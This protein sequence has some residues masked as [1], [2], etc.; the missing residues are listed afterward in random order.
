MGGELTIGLS[1]LYPEALRHLDVIASEGVEI[2]EEDVRRILW[3]RLLSG[4][5]I[6][7]REGAGTLWAGWHV[8]VIPEGFKIWNDVPYSGFVDIGA[9]WP[10]AGPRTVEAE[11]GIW[12]RQAVGGIIDPIFEDPSWLD[13]AVDLVIEYMKAQVAA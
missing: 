8:E 11:G 9:G 2:A 10:S 6:G 13:D 3:R 7:D 1:V 4:T 12:S 5:P